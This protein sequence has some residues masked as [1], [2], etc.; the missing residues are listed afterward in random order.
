MAQQ[1]ETLPLY[2][3]CL[4]TLHGDY[5][6]IKSANILTILVHFFLDRLRYHKIICGY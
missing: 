2:T 3:I 6:A 5:Q 1:N 4:L